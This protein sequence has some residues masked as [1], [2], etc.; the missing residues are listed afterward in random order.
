MSDLATNIIVFGLKG[1]SS[2][3]VHKTINVMSETG[4]N[5]HW[6]YCRYEVVMRQ[7]DGQRSQGRGYVIL[8]NVIVHVKYIL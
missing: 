3:F 1:Y 6:C 5:A 2:G 8:I 7:W 4:I